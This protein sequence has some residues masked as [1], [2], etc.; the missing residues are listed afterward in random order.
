MVAGTAYDNSEKEDSTLGS[1][2]GNLDRQEL[3]LEE[4]EN[5]DWAAG[6]HC[7]EVESGEACWELDD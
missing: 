7:S 3:G 6:P 2:E 1:E 5:P 4:G